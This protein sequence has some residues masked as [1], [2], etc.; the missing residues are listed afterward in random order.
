MLRRAHKHHDTTRL[1]TQAVID[2]ETHMDE[3][4]WPEPR[5]VEELGWKYNDPDPEPETELSSDMAQVVEIFRDGVKA[6]KAGEDLKN[7][8]TE[9][10]MAALGNHKVGAV[11]TPD[12]KQY[13]VTWPWRTTKAKPPKLCPHCE[14]EL[15]PAKP[16]STTRQKSISVKEV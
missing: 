12:G 4:T 5:N 13:K 10:L 15:E 9:K 3:G 6:I 7:D 16:E 8:A 14:G 2:F 1:I 11:Y